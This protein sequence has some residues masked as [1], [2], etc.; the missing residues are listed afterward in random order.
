MSWESI[1]I[2][3]RIIREQFRTMKSEHTSSVFAW[4]PS[5]LSPGARSSH[6]DSEGNV[7]RKHPEKNTIEKNSG[8]HPSDFLENIL[9]QKLAEKHLL[10]KNPYIRQ[11]F[12][13]RCTRLRSRTHVTVLLPCSIS[14]IQ[15]DIQNFR[16]S[17]CPVV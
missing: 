2:V 11:F 10:S 7:G 14:D 5:K 17:R 3:I 1:R 6:H 13:I 16:I 15:I 9:A 12:D 8:I 4:N